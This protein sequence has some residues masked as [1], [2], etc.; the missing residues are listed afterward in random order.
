M[1][2]VNTTIFGP[3]FPEYLG[4]CLL[5]NGIDLTTELLQKHHE[6]GEIVKSEEEKRAL[7]FP[8]TF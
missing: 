1:T 6:R 4:F 3:F 5:K 7:F 8:L 2:M